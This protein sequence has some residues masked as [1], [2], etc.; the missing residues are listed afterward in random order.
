MFFSIPA[1]G[2]AREKKPKEEP[3]KEMP[4]EEAPSIPPP[5]PGPPPPPP[6]PPAPVDDT[7][8]DAHAAAAALY[9][10]MRPDYDPEARAADEAP[11]KRI[12]PPA[13]AARPTSVFL[14]GLPLTVK[15]SELQ[16]FLRG[17]GVLQSIKKVRDRGVFNGCAIVT[18]GGTACVEIINQGVMFRRWRGAPVIN[19]H[20]QVPTPSSARWSGRAA[21]WGA[22]P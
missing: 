5:P 18:F 14:S 11:R 19:V 7:P 15:D 16:Q 9:P 6:P 2:K 12:A 22:R 3:K 17:C 1:T 20:T 10:S 21:R 4:K 13:D 8:A